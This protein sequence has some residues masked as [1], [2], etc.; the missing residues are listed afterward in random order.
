MVGAFN[1]SAD[2]VQTG[3]ESCRDGQVSIEESPVAAMSD[4]GTASNDNHVSNWTGIQ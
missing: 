4:Y 3:I 2:G 1:T